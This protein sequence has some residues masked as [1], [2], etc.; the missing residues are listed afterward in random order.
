MTRFAAVVQG[1]EEAVLNALVANEDMTGRAGHR[2]RA[3][4]RDRVA[5]LLANRYG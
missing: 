3:L 5:E 2:T 4:P 1:T